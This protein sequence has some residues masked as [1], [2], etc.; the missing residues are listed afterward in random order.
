VKPTN[1]D[2]AIALAS[3]HGFQGLEFN[4]REVAQLAEQEGAASVR[5]RFEDAG[6]RPSGFGLPVDWRSDEEKWRRGLEEL[7]RLAAAAA[8]L[9]TTRCFTWIM[10]SSDERPY[11]ENYRFHVERFTPIA[12]ILGQHQCRLGLEF[13]GPK[14]LRDARKH[15][16][17]YRLHDMLAMGKEIGPNVGL[18]LDCWHWYTSGASVV[19]VETIK[20]D[21][22]VYVHVSDAPAGVPV[23]QQIDNVRMLPGETGVIDVV[24]FLG[25]LKNTG[26]DGPLVVEPFK[27]ELNELPSDDA[28]LE[29]VSASLDEIMRRAGI[30]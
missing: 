5:R 11:E 12:R 9:G 20:P 6:L 7:P 19:D 17:I 25:A 23:D 2:A 27:K 8:D 22:V 15:P 10:P 28:R 3:K 30:A 21:E 13:I 16:F 29:R 18:L 26:Y 14:T 1:L 24:G 4:A